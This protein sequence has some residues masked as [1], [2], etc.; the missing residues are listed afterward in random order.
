MTTPDTD[1]EILTWELNGTACRELAQQVVDDAFVPAIILGIARG[2]LIPAG[3]SRTPWT[4][5]L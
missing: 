3:A 2:G 4:A 1:R 5:S